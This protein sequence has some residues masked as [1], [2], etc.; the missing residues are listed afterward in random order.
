MGCNHHLCHAVLPPARFPSPQ[1]AVPARALLPGTCRPFLPRSL[2]L[3]SPLRRSQPNQA[4]LSTLFSRALGHFLSF[5]DGEESS[6]GRWGPLP[7][8]LVYEPESSCQGDSYRSRGWTAG[9]GGREGSLE[10]SRW[11]IR[12]AARSP[13]KDMRGCV[14]APGQAPLRGEPEQSWVSMGSGLCRPLWETCQSLSGLQEGRARKQLGRNWGVISKEGHAVWVPE[15]GGAQ[16][17][18]SGLVYPRKRS[19]RAGTCQPLRAPSCPHFWGKGFLGP[20]L[21]HVEWKGLTSSPGGLLESQGQRHTKASATGTGA[22][23]LLPASPAERLHLSSGPRPPPTATH[24][25]PALP[26]PLPSL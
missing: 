4:R 11:G 3:P 16:R 6:F 13:S 22:G 2:P 25:A 15:A 18:S 7:L 12:A 9:L 20:L 23:L 19:P 26:G 24:P 14:A 10:S 21:P 17:P 1:G 5:C 8:E